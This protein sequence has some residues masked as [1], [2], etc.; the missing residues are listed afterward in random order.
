[1][2][3]APDWNV[4]WFRYCRELIDPVDYLSRPYY[5]QWIQAYAAMLVNSGM[6][7][8]AEIAGG[9][10]ATPALEMGPPMDRAFVRRTG[11]TLSLNTE[12]SID[13]A[14]CFAPGDTVRAA[15]TGIVTHT[16]LPGYLRGRRGVVEAYR[17]A[18]VLPDASALNED[19]AEPLYTV[20]FAAAELWPE[21]ADSPDRIFADLWER[22]LEPV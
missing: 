17:G 2:T 6:A 16:R 8:V 19:V 3:R 20:G 12:R 10:A 15:R 13:A 22:Y 14:P 18:H 11:M 1:M 5:D 21:A 7:T 4:D 9:G